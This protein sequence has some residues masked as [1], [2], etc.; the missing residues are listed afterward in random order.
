MSEWNYHNTDLGIYSKK[1]VSG[2]RIYFM[3]IGK[4]FVNVYEFLNNVFEHFAEKKSI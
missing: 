3:K 1:F 2:G 4:K